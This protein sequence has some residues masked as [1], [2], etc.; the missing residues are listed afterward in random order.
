LTNTY[1]PAIR[2]RNILDDPFVVLE[3][4]ESLGLE[5]LLVYD[6]TP[7][8]WLWM[9]DNDRREDA[10]F[11]A[12]LGFVYRM[13]PTSRDASLFFTEDGQIAAFGSAPPALDTWDVNARVVM[14]SGQDF[15]L[16]SRLFAGIGQANGDDVRTVTRFGGDA[17]MVWGR[18]AFSTFV[19]VN[20]WGPYDFHRDFN[21]TFPLQV[22]ADLSYGT[23]V[24]ILRSFDS[25]FGVRGKLRYLDAHSPEG[26]TLPEGDEPWANEYEI[27]TYYR[28]AL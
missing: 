12:S 2:A 11:A 6:P 19:K 24:D 17:R 3:N 14:A 21:L 20:D 18:T 7:A 1:F 13:Q 5:M 26:L 27:V 9:W 22:M 25:R 16:V 15:R 8:T 23:R 28:M 4:R 10:P